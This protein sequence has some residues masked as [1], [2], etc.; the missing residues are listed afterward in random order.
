ML[1]GVAKFGFG[2]PGSWTRVQDWKSFA[3]T[4]TATS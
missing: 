3:L 2:V 1:P 4:Q